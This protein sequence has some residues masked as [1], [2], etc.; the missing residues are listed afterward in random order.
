M[1]R[2]HRMTSITPTEFAAL[3]DETVLIDVRE[4]AELATARIPGALSMPMSTLGDHLDE[5]PAG[6]F[7][8]VCHSGMRSGR[9]AQSLVEQGHGAVSVAGGIVQWEQEGLP[10]HKG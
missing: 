5:L 6:T 7:Y 9:I 1:E 8:L 2:T 10:V 4:P 3:P